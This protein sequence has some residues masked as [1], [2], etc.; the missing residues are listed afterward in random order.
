MPKSEKIEYWYSVISG[1]EKANEE[2]KQFNISLKYY[3]Y[4]Y[5]P[6]S[7]KKMMIRLLNNSHDG[8]LFAPIFYNESIL[9]L[10][11]I[12][13][14]TIPVIIIDSNIKHPS[15]SASITQD[16]FKSG[17]LAGKLISLGSNNKKHVL[18]MKITPEIEST[19]I[20]RE[21]IKGF[22]D[23]FKKNKQVSNV[24]ISEITLTKIQQKFDVNMFNEIDSIFIPN[25]R[26]Y[27]VAE[28][29]KKNN[30]N[31]INIVGYDMLRD[32]VMYLKEGFIN[33]LINQNPEF[34]GYT[35]IEYLYKKIVLKKNIEKKI[36]L[37]IE[38]IVK[39][40]LL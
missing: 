31:K 24:S 9:F 38:I 19:S 30:L 29:L 6:T 25:S 2:F 4:D 14:L 13:K 7:F 20:Y 5:N 33:F 10:D 32:N 26:A 27:I 39:E 21:R 37:P 35:G 18:I 11:K 3:L 8:I 23:F 36:N 12:K 28:I 17:Y 15:I 1:I 16:A 34:Q 40:N 22:Y